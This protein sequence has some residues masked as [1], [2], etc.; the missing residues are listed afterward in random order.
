MI[1]QLKKRFLAFMIDYLIIISYVL[2]L[3]L[4]TTN[5]YKYFNVDTASITPI[6]GQI[7]AFISLTIP[8]FLYS[9]F[10]E[11]SKHQ[12]TIGK[13]IMNIFVT[14]NWSDRNGSILLRNILKFLPWEVAH[15]GIHWVIYYSD[16]GIDPPIWV[17]IVLIIPQIVI[18]VYLISIFLHKGTSSLYDKL[19]NTS[20][21]YNQNI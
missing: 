21:L 6:T 19:A 7:I 11:S 4:I 12:A 3:F 9:Y 8:V 20:V 18:V 10:L 14:N 5:I 15:L 13:R 2:L 17:M 1:Q 16:L